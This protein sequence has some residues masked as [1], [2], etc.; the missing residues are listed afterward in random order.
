M[1]MIYKVSVVLLLTVLSCCVSA[2]DF[3][4]PD[5]EKVKLENG[6]TLLLMEHK[7]VPLINIQVRVSAGAVDSPIEGLSD[8]TAE[9][10]RF[11]NKSMTKKE[12]EEALDFIGANLSTWSG[13]DVSGLQSSFHKKDKKTVIDIIANTLMSPTFNKD[14]LDKYLTRYS[15]QIEQRK[16]SPKALVGDYFKSLYFSDH[17]YSVQVMATQKSLSKINK[18]AIENFYQ[19]Y[20]Q[21]NN[22]VIAVVGDFQVKS[23]KQQVLKAFSGWKNRHKQNFVRIEKMKQPPSAQVLLVNKEDAKETTFYIGGKGIAR[24]NEDYVALEVINTILG[25]RFTSWLN[26]ALRVNAGLTYS[27]SSDFITLKNDG[28]FRISTFT[29]TSTTEEA[30]DLA[31]KTYYQL[32]NKG[33]NESILKSAKAY[34]KGQFPPKFETAGEL[35]ELLVDFEVLNINPS[36][37]NNFNTNVNELT[38]E[39]ANDLVKQYFPK[40]NLQFVLIGKADDIRKVAKKYGS[41]TEIEMGDQL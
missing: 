10:L 13:V 7:E 17:P 41:V 16:E 8:V 35:A 12:M 19:K 11:G 5:Y 31:L 1:Q 9:A 27:A 14:E 38:V 22:I 33:I 37:I 18:S 6:M 23:M 21:P 26:D 25:G 2:G 20:Y 4:L 34:V 24:N 36:F 28:Y 29:K 3:K 39:K 32:W 30:I 40:D 15:S